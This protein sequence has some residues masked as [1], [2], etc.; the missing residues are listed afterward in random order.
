MNIYYANRVA[1]VVDGCLRWGVDGSIDIRA[2]LAALAEGN[3]SLADYHLA[4]VETELAD[5][6]EEDK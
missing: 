3:M 4:R 5:F 2:A 6:T 1:N